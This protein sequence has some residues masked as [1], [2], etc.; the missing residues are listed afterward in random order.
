RTLATGWKLS[1]IYRISSGAWLSITSGQDRS[2]SGVTT[3]RAQQVSGN[4]YGTNRLTNFLNPAAFALPGL[5]SFGN[6]GTNTIQGPHTWQFDMAMVRV[7]KMRETQS[8]E[9]RIEA[10]NVTNSFRPGVG[11]FTSSIGAPVT[12]LSS[13]NFGQ[14]NQA[15][16]P[17][18]LQ[19]ALKYEF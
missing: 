3:Q 1:G 5:G 10:Y 7:F 9:A 2:L 16:D 18:L 12:N 19:F 14:I 13:G 6:M 15:L 8:V 11:P 4:P 17:R